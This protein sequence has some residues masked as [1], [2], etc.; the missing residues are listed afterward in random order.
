MIPIY[1][2]KL[3]ERKNTY[4]EGLLIGV[5]AELN[6][7]TI[8]TKDDYIGGKICYLDTLSIN[9]PN[10]LDSQG[11][12]IFASLQ[13]DGRGGDLVV[14]K[15]YPFYGDAPEIRDSSGKCEELNY[16]G[17][18]LF[19]SIGCFIDF[20]K[21]S[22]RVRGGAVGYIVEDFNEYKI[23]GVQE[24]EK[25][26]QHQE[27]II[28]KQIINHIDINLKNVKDNLES[29]I[30]KLKNVVNDDILDCLS[31][32]EDELKEA[33]ELNRENTDLSDDLSQIDGKKLAY[34]LKYNYEY[35]ELYK[36]IMEELWKTQLI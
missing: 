32:M 2:A 30:N 4:V 25:K 3:N 21:V 17:L 14:S 33:I 36:E 15:S 9:F 22:D 28:I 1:R 13:N 12:K 5:D 35:A 11:N 16:K 19:D 27:T 10:M 7:C 34:N 8:R 23:V 24:W 6:L 18:L 26:E 31:E 29:L 20:V